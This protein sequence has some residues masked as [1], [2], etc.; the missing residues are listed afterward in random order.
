MSSRTGQRLGA[1]ER[2]RCWRHIGGHATERNLLPAK[3]LRRP[4]AL[5]C[6]LPT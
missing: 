6:V 5:Q 2:R 4:V 1:A 3:M